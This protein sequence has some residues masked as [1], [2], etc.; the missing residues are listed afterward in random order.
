[1]SILINAIGFGIVSAAIL[2]LSS[3]ALSLQYGVSNIP[4][5]AHGEFLTVSAYVAYLVQR[6]TDNIILAL[7][8]GALAAALL[9]FT[10]NAVVLQPFV[11]KRTR[12][13]VL[14]I[15]TIGASIVV[16]NVLGLFFGHSNYSISFPSQTLQKFGPFQFTGF[17]EIIIV[18]A[19][20]VML[21][22]HVLLKYTTFGKAQRAVADSADLARVSGI[23]ATRIVQQTWLM[24]GFIAGVGGVVLALEVGSFLPTMG[25]D[26][27]LPTF[28][29][30]IV[31]GIGNPYGAMAGA[32]MI[33]LSTEIAAPYIDASYKGAIP[34]GV[35]IIFLLVRPQGI[36]RSSASLTA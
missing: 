21:A 9:A 34:F 16:Q 31:G 28:A 8:A 20:A 6:A 17:E 11:R 33:G 35:L 27:L 15:V 14:L 4:N 5:F 32:L 23:P 2:A 30:V 18:V 22:V 13:I 26:F 24:A 10:L 36:F 12:P 7:L 19:A 1:M 25:F 3:V 29:A